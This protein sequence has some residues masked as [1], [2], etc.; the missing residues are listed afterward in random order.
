MAQ[1]SFAHTKEGRPPEEWEP[2]D[3]HLRSVGSLRATSPQLSAPARGAS[4]AGFGTIWGNT[5]RRSRI[6]CARAPVATTRTDRRSRGGSITPRPVPSTPRGLGCRDGCSPTASRATTPD[7]RTMRAESQG[8]PR[9]WRSRVEPTDAAPRE[10][11][12]KPLPPLPKL[13]LGGNR[14]A[15][16]FALAFWTRMLFSCLVDAD[17]LA[18]E[19]FMNP[20][21]AA[22]RPNS[23]AVAAQLL[24]RLDEHLDQKRRTAADTPVNRR[25]RDV[26]AACRDKARLAPGLFSL[27]VPTGG[28]KTLSSLAFALDARGRARLVPGSL[29]HPVHEHHRAD[30]RRVS[31]SPGRSAVRGAGAPQQPGA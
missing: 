27:N 26:L 1:E 6:T 29:C 28:G 16:P 24:G 13:D 18:T 12:A 5:A 8:S 17:F 22:Q 31:H 9:G 19:W 10:L 2:L 21:R 7:C 20:E 30:R 15:A 14:A 25:R 23:A 11:L 3:E 4:W